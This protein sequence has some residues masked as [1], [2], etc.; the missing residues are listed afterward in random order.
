MVQD[1]GKRKATIIG[2]SDYDKLPAEQQLP[3][4]KNDGEGIYSVLRRQKYNIP[5]DYKLI[6]R[7]K[8]YKMKKAI[9][10][11]FQQY[12]ELSKSI[13]LYLTI[14]NETIN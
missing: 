3:F 2:V 14:L 10:N 8:G 13:L 11:F 5:N 9:L 6:G 7:V 1:D 4:C 12:S